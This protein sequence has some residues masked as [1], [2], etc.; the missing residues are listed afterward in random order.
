MYY[1]ST[2]RKFDE[3]VKLNEKVLFG[4]RLSKGPMCNIPGIVRGAKLEILGP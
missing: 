1:V 4:S 2:F 3:D